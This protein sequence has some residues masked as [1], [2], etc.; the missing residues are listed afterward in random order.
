M[1]FLLT[2]TEP[3]DFTG[4]ICWKSTDLIRSTITFFA[5]IPVLAIIALFQDHMSGGLAAGSGK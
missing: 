3:I 4:K 1:K 5:V 2:S